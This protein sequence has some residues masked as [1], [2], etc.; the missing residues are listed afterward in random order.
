[1]ECGSPPP[2]SKMGRETRPPPRQSLA[3]ISRATIELAPQPALEIPPF[4]RASAPLR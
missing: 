4:L 3:A 2:L 1:M